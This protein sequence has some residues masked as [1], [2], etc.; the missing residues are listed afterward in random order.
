MHTCEQPKLQVR[1]K[2]AQRKSCRLAAIQGWCAVRTYTLM[3]VHH[4]H[5]VL[6]LL[7]QLSCDDEEEEKGDLVGFIETGN[8]KFVCSQK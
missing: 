3:W 1:R 2:L 5:A 7:Q 8:S 4:A 6:L